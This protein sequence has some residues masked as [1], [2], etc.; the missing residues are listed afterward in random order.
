VTCLCPWP[1]E[2]GIQEASGLGD[3]RAHRG[4]LAD[5]AEVAS[6][7]LAACKRRDLIVVPGLENRLLVF[8]MRFA[9]RKMNTKVSAW[10]F[11][12]V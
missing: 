8:A 7:G 11:E 6:I 1:T 12:R 5:A 4:K 10:M 2:S 3:S 9:P